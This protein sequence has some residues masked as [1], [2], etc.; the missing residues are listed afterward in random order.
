VTLLGIDERSAAVWAEGAWQAAG[1]GVVTVIK[2][3]AVE[4]F[5]SGT[6]ISGLEN[7]IRMLPA[8]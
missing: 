4:Q 6:K 1:P 5:K 8:T 3:S 7:P 2:G